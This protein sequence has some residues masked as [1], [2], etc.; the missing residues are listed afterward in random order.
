LCHVIFAQH[1]A[2]GAGG[3]AGRGRASCRG[4]PLDQR[5]VRL[6]QWHGHASRE[7]ILKGAQDALK[8]ISGRGLVWPERVKLR[9]EAADEVEARRTDKERSGLLIR[10]REAQRVSPRIIVFSAIV[11]PQRV[12]TTRFATCGCAPECHLPL[13]CDPVQLQ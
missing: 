7:V 13:A 3:A 5:K 1:G 12:G 8:R 4:E 11:A 6:Q 9:R 10:R 2:R